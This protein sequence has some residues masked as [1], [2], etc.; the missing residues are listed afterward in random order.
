MWPRKQLDISWS[1]LTFG[2]RQVVTPGARP[3]TAA[4][5]GTEWVPADEAI[6]TLS[7]R[8]GLDLLLTAL[9]LPAESEVII[10]AVTIP[11]MARIVKHHQ[12]VA[13]PVDVDGGTLQ[14]SIE[15]IE[16]SVTPR[17]RAIL[18]AHLFGTHI[19]MGPIIELA[20]QHN[21]LVIEDCAQAFVGSAYAG[22]PD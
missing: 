4:V 1:D 12:L 19:D 8:S 15:H 18:V 21:L 13:V 17:T 3:T 6:L 10:S 16:R 14:P 7:V 20:Q 22:H 5:V 9:A 11:D 2:L